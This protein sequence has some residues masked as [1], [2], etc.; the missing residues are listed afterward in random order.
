MREK[1]FFILLIIAS[2]FGWAAVVLIINRVDPFA[3][4][5]SL[6]ALFYLSVGLALYGTLF[7]LGWFLRKLFIRRM[8]LEYYIEILF[9]QTVLATLLIILL[10]LLQSARLLSWWN[11]LLIVL[12]IILLEYFFITYKK[13]KI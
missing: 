10:L 2:T 9:R 12:A 5:L 4:N 7:L 3:A 11:S 8:S 13:T 1:G 6:F